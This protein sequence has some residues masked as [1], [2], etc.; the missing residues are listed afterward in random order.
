M[1]LGRRDWD[2]CPELTLINLGFCRRAVKAIVTSCPSSVS[3][4]LCMRHGH[5]PG[6]RPSGQ[7]SSRTPP[8]IFSREHRTET[9]F[10]A[11]DAGP[12]NLSIAR[13]FL[14]HA[15]A[16]LPTPYSLRRMRIFHVR[17]RFETRTFEQAPCFQ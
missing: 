14:E 17:A 12:L 1:R 11:Q 3:S 15:T 9:R 8:A 7:L 4:S 10:S 6:I 2:E 16:S 13:A 5:L